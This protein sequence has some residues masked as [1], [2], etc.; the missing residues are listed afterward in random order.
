MESCSPDPASKSPPD[1]RPARCIN[2][3]RTP[4]SGERRQ[5]LQNTDVENVLQVLRRLQ[6]HSTSTLHG[7]EEI[8]LHLSTDQYL[9]LLKALESDQALDNYAKCKARYDSQD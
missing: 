1:R 8:K 9:Q 3:S 6:N 5:T 2:L 7:D 4:A